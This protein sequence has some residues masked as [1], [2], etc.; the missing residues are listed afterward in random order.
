MDQLCRWLITKFFLF[1]I[2]PAVQLRLFYSALAPWQEG[3]L[4]KGEAHICL[5]GEQQEW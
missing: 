3:K 1:I 5:P 4:E 2:P